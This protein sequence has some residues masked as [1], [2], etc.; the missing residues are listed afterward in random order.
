MSWHELGT[1]KKWSTGVFYKHIKKATPEQFEKAKEKKYGDKKIITESNLN[2]EEIV[3]VYR[4]ME[5]YPG[6]LKTLPKWD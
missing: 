1:T 5:D 2:G 3:I 6:F 4:I